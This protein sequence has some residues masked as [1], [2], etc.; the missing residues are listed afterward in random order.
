MI[1][2]HERGILVASVLANLVIVV[3]IAALI[4]NAPDWITH[5]P[6]FQSFE[7]KATTTALVVILMI[8]VAPI[9]RRTRVALLRENSVQLGLAQ[10][11]EIFEILERECR[12]LEITPM[13]EVYISR[14]IKTLSTSISLFRGDRV[15]VLHGDL[16]TGVTDLERRLDVYSFFIGYELGRLRLG[17][18]SFWQELFL[19]YLKRI[20][21]LRLPLLTVQT[22]S[23]DRVSAVLAPNGIRG[24]IF[25]A[26][27]GD[28]LDE[29]DVADYVR[30]VTQG[31]SSWSWVASIVRPEPHVSTRVRALYADGFFTLDRDLAR[32]TP[33]PQPEMH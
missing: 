17:H 28:V 10:V 26:A 4:V 12:A 23:R 13:P 11:P 3:A 18:A 2:P 6:H 15:I 1:Y 25:H 21:L 31:P 33:A 30:K 8:P 19:G 20:P 24:L 27:G 9:M 29:I 14:A 22:F 16:F 7:Q 5:H 32:L